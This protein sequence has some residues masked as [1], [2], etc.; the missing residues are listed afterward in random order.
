[1]NKMAMTR[2]DNENKI[3]GYVCKKRL[4]Y[5]GKIIP[6]KSTVL[7]LRCSEIINTVLLLPM[8]Q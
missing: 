2:K 4:P 3:L 7:Y 6:A 8:Y 1:M 5:L